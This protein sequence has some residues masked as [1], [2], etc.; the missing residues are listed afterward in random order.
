MAE[1]RQFSYGAENRARC[2]TFGGTD[3]NAVLGAIAVAFGE[4]DR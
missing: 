1:K 3:A 4:W 2:D